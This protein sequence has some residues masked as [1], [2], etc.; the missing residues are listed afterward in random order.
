MKI[1]QDY[2]ELDSAEVIEVISGNYLGNLLIEVSFS[3][4]TT[5]RVDFKPFLIK[6]QQPSI[7]KY[8]DEKLFAKFSLNQGN[9]NWNDYDLIFPVSNLHEG[10]IS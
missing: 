5:K 8:L 7:S 4:N 1:T 9:L 2:T 10:S 3:D 6:A